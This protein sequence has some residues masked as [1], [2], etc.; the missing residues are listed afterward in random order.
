MKI[1]CAA[2]K[3]LST[4]LVGKWHW[5]QT[6]LRTSCSK[7]VFLLN[8]LIK[9]FDDILVYLYVM[10]YV[11]CKFDRKW[12]LCSQSCVLVVAETY[13]RNVQHIYYL[14][15]V[16]LSGIMFS[17]AC[18]IFFLGQA[19]SEDVTDLNIRNLTHTLIWTYLCI[20]VEQALLVR[21]RC[22]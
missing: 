19:L 8:L 11:T 22:S 4:L 7:I 16:L 2:L 21:F 1:I 14:H 15:H 3:K 13:D 18:D 17:R 10:Y 20:T 12:T 5:P 9:L 6:K